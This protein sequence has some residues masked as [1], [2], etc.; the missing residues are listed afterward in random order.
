MAADTDR[1]TQHDIASEA[2]S[3]RARC[4]L[5]APLPQLRCWG[6]LRSPVVHAARVARGTDS[7]K[8]ITCLVIFK[9]TAAPFSFIQMIVL[10]FEVVNVLAG[11]RKETSSPRPWRQQTSLRHRGGLIS[12]VRR[13]PGSTIARLSSVRSQFVS[14]KRSPHPC[15]LHNRSDVIA[16]ESAGV[17]KN[18]VS[19]R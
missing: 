4:Q 10:V 2:T 15:F 13:L 12:V 19:W 5:S 3:P 7:S 16:T 6:S 18:D 9:I 1:L 17:W 11:L 14:Q 8:G